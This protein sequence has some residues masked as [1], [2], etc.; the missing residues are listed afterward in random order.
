MLIFYSMSIKHEGI[1]EIGGQY[2]KK[3]LQYSVCE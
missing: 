2:D 1:Q 3:N